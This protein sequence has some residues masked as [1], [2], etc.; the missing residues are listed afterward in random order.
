MAASRIPEAV[1]DVAIQKAVEAGVFP[2]R[3][4]E[5]DVAMNKEVMRAILEAA[6]DAA[7]LAAEQNGDSPPSRNMRHT[8]REMRRCY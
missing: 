5:F 2:R 4:T 6:F 3:G 8:R 1:L 7:A